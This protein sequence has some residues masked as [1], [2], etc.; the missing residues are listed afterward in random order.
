MNVSKRKFEDQFLDYVGD[1]RPKP[2]CVKL[3]REVVEDVW[4]KRQALARSETDAL[5]SRIRALEEKRAKLLEAHV[6]QKTIADDLYRREDER[7]SGEIAL[8]EMELSDAQIEELDLDGVL[9]FAEEMVLD[10]RRLWVQGGLEQRQRLQE[11]MFPKGVSYDLETG[12]GT[13]R[14]A[15]FFSWLEAI[16]APKDRLASPGGVEPPFSP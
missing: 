8:A 13:A 1:L 6:Y 11:V 9:A 4:E 7:L 5:V 12:F 14:T 3:F 16:P 15:M 10:A 2:E